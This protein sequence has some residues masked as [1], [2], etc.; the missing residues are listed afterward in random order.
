MIHV[1]NLTEYGMNP[2]EINLIE[3][4]KPLEKEYW[5]KVSKKKNEISKEIERLEN[6]SPKDETKIEELRN[7]KASIK[8]KSINS[9]K[10]NIKDYLLRK[11]FL[12]CYYCEGEFYKNRTGVGEP[13][14]D[15]IADKG[16]YPLFLYTPKNLVLACKECNGFNKKGTENVI[17]ENSSTTDY[18]IF[19]SQDFIIIHPYLDRKENHMEYIE[20]ANI[21]R[22][23]NNSPKGKETIR[24]FGLNQS[25][26]VVEKFK[27]TMGSL[28]ETE[29]NYIDTV[30]HYRE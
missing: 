12:R 13:T 27:D 29:E 15:H 24:M 3:N 8:L 17:S 18:N 30:T 1:N 28:T 26:C 11:Q 14:I 9:L 25:Y 10:H 20:H 22:V 5:K 23:V 6:K 4:L 16:T 21:W 19:T 2:L 7:I